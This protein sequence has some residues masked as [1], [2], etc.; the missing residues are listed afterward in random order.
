LPEVKLPSALPRELH[1]SRGSFPRMCEVRVGGAN[2]RMPCAHPEVSARH[3]TEVV[4]L[5]SGLA[6]LALELVGR[7][8]GGSGAGRDLEG[9]TGLRVAA[10]AGRALA[11]LEDA[12]ARQRDLVTGDERLGDCL[13]DGA[14]GLVGVG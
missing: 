13:E 2:A 11:R 1:T 3:T 14:D 4:S 12:E 8:E 6:Q 5:A 10:G 9:L 7:L